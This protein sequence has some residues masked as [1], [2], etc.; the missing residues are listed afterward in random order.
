MKKSKSI[1]IV[2]LI[3]ILGIG[4]G[5][6]AA[7]LFAS[8]QVL[9]KDS[10]TVKT[11]LDDLYSKVNYGN[12]TAAQILSGKTAL[13]G[14]S[15]ITGSMAN[16][17]SS[18]P[19]Q[20][21]SSNTTKVVLGDAAYVTDLYNTSTSSSP[22]KYVEIR[23]NSTAGYITGN[24][25]FAVPQATM[26]SAIGLTAAKIAKGNTILGIAGTYT[27]GNAKYGTLSATTNTNYTVNTGLSSITHFVLIGKDVTG[28]WINTVYSPTLL[29]GNYYMSGMGQGSRDWSCNSSKV[30][31]GSSGTCQDTLFRVVSVSG[32]NITLKSPSKTD[33]WT[34]GTVYWFAY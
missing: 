1:L 11:A 4:T 32:G 28:G 8:D 15:K 10:T 30:A 21:T 33:Y 22:G 12:A 7:T 9:Y 14:G 25:L 20:H 34:P 29:G 6:G 2:L 18:T 16:L 23:Y 26:A 3:F 19:Y 17:S 13:V 27:G 5:I 31:V 24:T